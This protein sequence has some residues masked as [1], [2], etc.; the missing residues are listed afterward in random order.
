MAS[1]YKLDNGTWRVSISLGK[2]AN[3][4]LIRDTKQGFKYKKDAEK[5]VAEILNN[6]NKGFAPSDVLLKDYIYKWFNDNK[7]HSLNSINTINGY[8]SKI[9]NHIIPL[10]GYYKISEL[11]NDIIQ[12]FYNKLINGYGKKNRISPQSAKKVMEVLNGCLKYAY[13]SKLIAYL[14]TDIDRV[15]CEKPQ[16]KY[17]SKKEVDFYLDKINGSYLHTPILLCLLTG[18][19]VGELCGLRW[20]DFN[21]KYLEI[22]NQV[23]QDKKSKILHLTSI[24]KTNTSKRSI[25]L[26]K[27]LIDHLQNIKDEINPKDTDFIIQ[28]RKGGMANPKN[29]SEDF[30]RNVL[31]YK[32]DLTPISIHCLRHT[33]ATL[34]ILNGVNVKIVSDRLGHANINITLETYTHVMEEM[35]KDSADLLDKIFCT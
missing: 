10:L 32:E 35:K 19:R 12:D 3:G 26:P 4:K 30:K 16:I 17:W 9:D 33:H 22:N 11:K 6:H 15:K 25:Y 24:L 2:D 21:G 5:Y 13:K 31:K 7:K 34:L 18:I 1:I 29:I 20:C 8:I 23:L 28:D 14:P 27:I